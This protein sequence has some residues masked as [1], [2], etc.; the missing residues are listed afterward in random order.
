ML[1]SAMARGSGFRQ[2]MPDMKKALPAVGQAPL[3]KAPVMRPAQLP[4]D[5]A[6]APETIRPAAC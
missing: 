1:Q 5:A 3:F 2:G 4:D 6:A